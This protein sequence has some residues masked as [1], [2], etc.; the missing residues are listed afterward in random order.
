MKKILISIVGLSLMLG[1]LPACGGGS[2][3]D[4]FVSASVELGCAMFEDPKFLKDYS[5]VEGKTKEIF[6]KYGFDTEDQTAMEAL[7][8]KYQEDEEVIKAVQ[9]GITECAGDLFG[10]MMLD[11]SATTPV[12]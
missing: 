6:A 5:L 1:L 7:A 3:K 11:K 10:S 12:E 9:E 8:A 2:E 4:M